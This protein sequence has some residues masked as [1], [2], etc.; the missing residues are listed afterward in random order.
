M[1]IVGQSTKYPTLYVSVKDKKNKERLRNSATGG[2]KRTWQMMQYGILDC[3]LE[4]KKI[5]QWKNW[6][7]LNN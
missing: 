4:Q 5:I 3:I 7:N 6:R 2:D 1:H